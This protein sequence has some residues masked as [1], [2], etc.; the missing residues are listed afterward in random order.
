[1]TNFTE[2]R[3][4]TTKELIENALNALADRLDS[5]CDYS[6]HPEIITLREEIRLAATYAGDG[7]IMTACDILR[8]DRSE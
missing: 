3:A 4:L 2:P 1:M 7:A 8:G 5:N 6:L